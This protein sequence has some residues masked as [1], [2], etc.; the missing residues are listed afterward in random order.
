MIRSLI[1]M[2][3]YRSAG[4]QTFGYSAKML[5]IPAIIQAWAAITLLVL[6][7]FFGVSWVFI[8][9][10]VLATV[11][12]HLLSELTLYKS[13]ELQTGANRSPL[14]GFSL[15]YLVYLATVSLIAFALVNTHLDAV[16]DY[17][18]RLF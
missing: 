7:P 18:D 6:S 3:S 13:V 1:I 2:I 16:L 12:F 15:G 14:F 17:L 4:V 9:L 11:S 8:A 5:T 10:A